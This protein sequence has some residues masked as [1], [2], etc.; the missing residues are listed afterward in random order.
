MV[1]S[2]DLLSGHIEEDFPEG[3]ASSKVVPEGETEKFEKE[4]QDLEEH[5][6]ALDPEPY[7]PYNPNHKP[8]VADVDDD[9]EYEYDLKTSK[10]HE[11]LDH[12]DADDHG[13]LIPVGSDH[14]LQPN[15][16][17]LPTFLLEPKDSYVIKNKPAT[18]QC[19]AANALKVN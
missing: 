16:D 14:I 12:H 6:V 17:N 8:P 9:H 4:S 11:D 15:S 18:L 3:K 5:E 19:R 10:G 7:D 13:L 2:G 1:L